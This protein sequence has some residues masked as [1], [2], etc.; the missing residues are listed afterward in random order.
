ME[1]H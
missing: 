1:D